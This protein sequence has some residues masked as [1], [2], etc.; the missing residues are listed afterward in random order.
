VKTL[1]FE[2]T[3]AKQVV[4]VTEE[5]QQEIDG[6]GDGLC[7]LFVLHTTAALTVMDLDP[8]T[9]EDLLDALD[10]LSPKLDYRHPHDPSHVTDHILSALIGP[11]LTVPVQDGRLRL[12]T[13]QRIVL[14]ELDG[15]RGRGVVVAFVRA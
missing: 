10:A 6:T 14:V 5:V 1:T 7:H 11:A 15:P 9:D 8:G 2:T 12:G 4:D 3:R 13:W